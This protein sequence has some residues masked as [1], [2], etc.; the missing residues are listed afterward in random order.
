MT[1]Y[2]I[3]AVRFRFINTPKFPNDIFQVQLAILHLW[4]QSCKLISRAFS[5]FIGYTANEITPV[6]MRRLTLP[7][8]YDFIVETFQTALQSEFLWEIKTDQDLEVDVEVDHCAFSF[9]TKVF[10]VIECDVF[11]H[12]HNSENNIF[13]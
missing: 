13:T 5:S 10:L 3:P 12:C 9:K 2:F 1:R 4:L 6:L 8:G 11:Y 7:Y